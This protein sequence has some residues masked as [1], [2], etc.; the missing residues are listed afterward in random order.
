[1][2]PGVL[3]ILNAIIM[4]KTADRMFIDMIYDLLAKT[5]ESTNTPMKILNIMGIIMY[6]KYN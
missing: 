5:F 1:M 2:E 3:T 6:E 4:F